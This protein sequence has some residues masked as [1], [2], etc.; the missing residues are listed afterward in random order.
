M[1]VGGIFSGVAGAVFQTSPIWL[2]NGLASTI[3]GGAPTW[4]QESVIGN[5]IPL[6]LY[7]EALNTVVGGIQQAAGAGVLN[8]SFANFKPLPGSTLARYK[9]AEYPFYTQQIAAN[10]SIQEPLNI[11]MLMVCPAT[12]STSLSAIKMGVMSLLQNVVSNHVQ[13]G[14]TFTVMTPSYVYTDC[15]LTGIT[16]VST[17]ETL[18]TQW[19]YQWDFT[20]PLLTSAAQG[21][22]N[23]AMTQLSSF[24]SLP[25]A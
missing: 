5:A 23:S 25:A 1:S 21:D 6:S 9:I 4:L 14:G 24:G 17:E 22:M 8:Q 7:T 15:L 10:A 3:M 16:D 19:A 20:Q 12:A 18:Q 11:S 13:L 2:T